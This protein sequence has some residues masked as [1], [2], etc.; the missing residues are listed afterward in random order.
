V[1]IGERA[2]RQHGERVDRAA[3]LQRG[4]NPSR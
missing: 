3:L 2:V 1:K 4:K